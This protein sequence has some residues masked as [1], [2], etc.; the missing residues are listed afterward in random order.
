MLARSPR[1][2]LR[3]EKWMVLEVGWGA[4]GLTGC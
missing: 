1:E 4:R 3:M 2:I